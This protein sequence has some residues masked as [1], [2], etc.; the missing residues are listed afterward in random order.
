MNRDFLFDGLSSWNTSP[1]NNHIKLISSETI[2]SLF[3]IFLPPIHNTFVALLI[4]ERFWSKA[5]T[6]KPI[7][8]DHKTDFNAKWLLK[9]I[10]GRQFRCQCL[11]ENTLKD[12]M[13]ILPII[14]VALYTVG[15]RVEV[16]NK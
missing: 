12:Y 7:H 2:D 1:V 14:I 5:R 13:Y 3:Y 9:V 8:A 15:L 16:G 4:S 11:S 6:R 10:Q